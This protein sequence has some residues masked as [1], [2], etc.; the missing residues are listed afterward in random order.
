[1]VSAHRICGRAVTQV[2]PTTPYMDTCQWGNAN[3]L[4]SFSPYICERAVLWLSYSVYVEWEHEQDS[5]K[6]P[7]E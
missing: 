5:S 2:L 4:G 3:M 1:M 6:R 7:D